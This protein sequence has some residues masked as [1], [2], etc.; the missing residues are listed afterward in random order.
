MPQGTGSQVAATAKQKSDELS[1]GLGERTALITRFRRA[2]PGSERT[3]DG[4]IER[5]IIPPYPRESPKAIPAEMGAS[6]Q[7]QFG[8][9]QLCPRPGQARMSQG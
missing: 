5:P 3:S 9:C 7:R 4:Y 2:C 6:G 1:A 8:S